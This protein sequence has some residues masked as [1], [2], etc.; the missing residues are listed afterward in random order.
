MAKAP[1]RI[2]MASGIT[3]AAP[4]PCTVRAAIRVLRDERIVHLALQCDKVRSFNREN[5]RRGRV[6]CQHQTLSRSGPGLKIRFQLLPELK[7]DMFSASN[8]SC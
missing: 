1:L 6:H 8:R 2:A 7:I 5:G 3:S 4:A